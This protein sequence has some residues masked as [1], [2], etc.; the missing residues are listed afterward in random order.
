MCVAFFWGSSLS[1]LS[2]TLYLLLKALKQGLSFFDA[3]NQ[4]NFAI[5]VSLN[6]FAFRNPNPP[7]ALGL[8]RWSHDFQVQNLPLSFLGHHQ[9]LRVVASS[10]SHTIVGTSKVQKVYVGIACI[11]DL[12]RVWRLAQDKLLLLHPFNRASSFSFRYLKSF[13]LLLVVKR[14]AP[15]YLAFFETFYICKISFNLLF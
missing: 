5:K 8:H 7:W 13:V 14:G 10:L 11:T 15:R 4:V 2:V 1:Q 9:N 3:I 6:F 12:M